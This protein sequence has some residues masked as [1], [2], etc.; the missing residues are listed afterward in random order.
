MYDQKR[1]KQRKLKAI[2]AFIVDE[3]S[4]DDKYILS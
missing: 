1:K 3:A 4:C 2:K